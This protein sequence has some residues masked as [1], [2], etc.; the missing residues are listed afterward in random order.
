MLAL[1]STAHILTCVPYPT[2]SLLSLSSQEGPNY[3]HGIID[4]KTEAP[5][6]EET[7]WG[8]GRARLP[9]LV[10]M[11]VVHGVAE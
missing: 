1:P 10:W 8:R 6:G 9:R 5:R 4:E 3:L 7:R 11:L 2:R